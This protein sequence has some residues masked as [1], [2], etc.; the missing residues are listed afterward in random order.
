MIDGK[1]RDAVEE[2]IRFLQPGAAYAATFDEHAIA[3][4]RRDAPGTFLVVCADCRSLLAIEVA[5]RRV[6]LTIHRHTGGP[7]SSA[8]GIA[9]E[10]VRVV[11]RDGADMR[12]MIG[13]VEALAARAKELGH[14]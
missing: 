2:A 1:I 9:K 8:E 6:Y 3:I 10:L 13:G 4:I 12:T 5:T 7:A 11:E 14:G